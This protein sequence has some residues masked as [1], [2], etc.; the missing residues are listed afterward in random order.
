MKKIIDCGEL[1]KPKYISAEQL[2][3]TPI[4]PDIGC[5]WETAT[6]ELAIIDYLFGSNKI[7]KVNGQ[8]IDF[9][10]NDRDDFASVDIKFENGII[11]S[12][13]T[14]WFSPVR[15]R[16]M[17]IG[18]Q[19]GI[20]TFDD[21]ALEGK[22]KIYRIPFPVEE[23]KKAIT[24]INMKLEDYPCESPKLDQYEP[25]QNELDAFI[26]SVKT[27]KQPL[28]DINHGLR[29]TTMLDKIYRSF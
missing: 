29:V 19:K 16:R 15:S 17:M 21:R 2:Y 9:S 24:S 11:C 25:L 5:F 8:A 18:F 4:R 12:I 7:I 26:D 14:S 23:K 20:I 28:T 22:L 1:G 3:F 10:G 6:H 27:G 13:T